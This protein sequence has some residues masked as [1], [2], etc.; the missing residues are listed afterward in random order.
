MNGNEIMSSAVVGTPVE[1]IQEGA[2][3]TEEASEDDGVIRKLSDYMT[4][5]EAL[6]N[7][8]ILSRGQT[9]DYPLLPSALRKDSRGLGYFLVELLLT[10]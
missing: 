7:G 2:T 8:Y 9:G 4:L 10:F 3:H 5:V 1:V 6:P